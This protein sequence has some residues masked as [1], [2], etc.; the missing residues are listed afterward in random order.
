[1]AGSTG[2]ALL[3][4]VVGLA[5]LGTAGT[6]AVIA[7]SEVARSVQVAREAEDESRRAS[8]FMDAATL[9]TRDDLDRR[10]GE[11]PQ[12]PWKMRIQRID[13]MLYELELADSLTG[14]TVLRTSVYRAEHV[15]R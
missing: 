15:E 7:A 5:I 10:L 11:R 3:E 14:L 6:S 2:S 8:A 4:V 1:M 13:P 9:W 12:G